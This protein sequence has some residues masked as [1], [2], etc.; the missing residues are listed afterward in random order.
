MDWLEDNIWTG[1]GGILAIAGIALAIYQSALSRRQTRIAEEEQAARRERERLA[2][3]PLPAPPPAPPKPVWPAF[4]NLPPDLDRA[5]LGR[6]GAVADLDALF[7]A[8]GQAAPTRAVAIHAAGGMGKTSLARLYL[9]RRRD[10]F[11]GVWWLPSEQIAETLVPAVDALGA[12]IG[13]RPEGDPPARAAAIWAALAARDRPW[14]LAFDNAPDYATIRPWL[15]H[16]P[17]V[18]LLLTS[19]HDDFPPDRIRTLR[20]ERLPD[21][22]AAD[23]LAREARRAD[24]HPG[25]LRLAQALEGYPLALVQA[26]AYARETTLSFD[27]CRARIEAICATAPPADYPASVFATLE[28]TLARIDADADTGPDEWALL[29]LIPWLA[30]DG[31]DAA[32]ILDAARG[33]YAQMLAEAIPPGLLALAQAPDRLHRALTRLAA[34]SLL[35]V[36]G[37]GD[38]R[39]AAMHRLTALAL[40][41]GLS[42][43]APTL[44]AAAAAVAAAGQPFDVADPANWPVCARLAAHVEALAAD[45]PPGPAMEFLLSQS[46]HY[47]RQHAM[48]ATATAQARAALNLRIARL[49]PEDPETHPLHNSLGQLL[50]DAGDHEGAVAQHQRAL[51]ITQAQGQDDPAMASSLASLGQALDG[52]AHSQRLAGD[53]AAAD[54][55]LRRAASLQRLAFKTHRRLW[56]RPA[57]P[58][59]LAAQ[60]NN[61]A[62]TFAMQGRPGRAICFSA[63]ALRVRRATL[64]PGDYRLARILNN[65]G[66][67]H[68]N[69]GDPARARP[70]L[71][72]ALAL[73]ESAFPGNPPHPD[74]VM[75]ADWLATCLFALNQDAEAETLCARYALDPARERA[76]AA[77]LARKPDA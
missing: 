26:G 9:Q 42:A 47:A 4:A 24:D 13:L 62:H 21:A 41:R 74:R 46:A 28:L 57:R 70:H 16:G 1:V 55:T 34:R 10:R 33:P 49:G 54:A 75:T 20:L 48:T 19:R 43:E 51:Q 39:R 56:P 67:Y 7:A 37:A 45:P 40:R 71:S 58:P 73:L 5:I 50:G 2:E 22:T 31:I 38:A 60:L 72:E 65:L 29:R 76:D 59:E 17:H 15:G 3:P 52:L 12:A 63:A 8:P 66:S 27:D 30:P 64:P 32:L 35:T 53:P 44:R 25:A 6:D 14:L 69:A 18:R 77:A 68:L 11:E 23:V 36:S 61:M